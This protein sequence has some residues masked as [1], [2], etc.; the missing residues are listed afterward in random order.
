MQPKTWSFYA[1]LACI[2]VLAT[3]LALPLLQDTSPIRWGLDLQGGVLVTYRPDFSQRIPAYENLSEQELLA[4]AKDTLDSRLI[5]SLNTQPDVVIRSDQNIVVSVAGQADQRK[6]LELIGKTYHLSLRLVAGQY[7]VPVEGKDLHPYGGRYLE[8]EPAKFSGDMMDERAIQANQGGTLE[9][10]L[11]GAQVAFRFRPPH[12]SEFA[13]FTGKHVGRQLAILLDDEVEWAGTI[14]SAIVGSGVLRGG[15]SFAEATEI[16]SMLKSGSLPVSLQVESLSA[17][18]PSLGQEIQ[19]LGFQALLFSLAI[20]LLVLGVAYFHRSWFLVTGLASLGCLLFFIAGLAAA[21]DLTLDMVGIAGIILSVGMGMD[22]FIIVLESLERKLASESDQGLVARSASFSRGIY[23]MS[24]EGRTLFHA[25]AT[26][27]GVVLMLLGT[28]RLKSFAVFILVGIAASALTI[29][30]T[31]EILHRTS[32]LAGAT[33]PDLLAWLRRARPG[34][35]RA[36]WAYAAVLVLGLGIV[37]LQLF[38]GS[39]QLEFGDDFRPGTQLIVSAEEEAGLRGVLEDLAERLPGVSVKQQRLGS[40]ESKRSLITLGAALD[41]ET[42]GV[43]ELIALLNNHAVDFESVHSIDGKVSSE[44]LLQ[45][46]SVLSMS[47]LFLAAYFLLLQRPIDRFFLDRQRD[48][49]LPNTSWWVVA[50]ILVALF[51][52]VAVLLA[53]I[54]LLQ[55]PINLPVIAAI[56]TIVG[57]SVNDSVVLWSHIQNRWSR[58]EARLSAA[59]VVRGSVDS[60]LS[61]AILTSLSTMVPALTI[62]VVG[63]EPL[64]DFAWVMIAGTVAGTLSSMFIVGVFAQ[65]GLEREQESV[66]DK[67]QA[68]VQGAPSGAG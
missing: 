16:A 12:D 21:F 47:F 23:N 10:S 27:L 9:E 4:L 41:G 42:L 56:L 63:L 46:L 13:D 44:R 14:E 62:L 52:D 19:D 7:E 58:R 55:I 2:V 18:G 15:Y 40:P 50:G 31:R 53:V 49:G 30:M 6:V 43:E 39:A 36:R 38:Q 29:F 1:M 68:I 17:V 32:H 64:A 65:R 66:K 35:F 51:A 22:A 54:A 33:R 11:G 60:I 34:L 8:L 48:K 3:S 67:G 28:D 61:R 5:H 26:T 59:A 20:L 57:Y 24:R 37:G 45:G 25:N